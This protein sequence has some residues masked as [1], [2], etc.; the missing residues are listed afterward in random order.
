LSG[1]EIRLGC[2]FCAPQEPQELSAA[3]SIAARGLV[4]EKRGQDL[5]HDI[6]LGMGADDLTIRTGGANK[7]TLQIPNVLLV[8]R[9][10]K[11][12]EKL[13]AVKPDQ[14]RSGKANIT[15]PTGAPLQSIV[16]SETS[17]PR[18]AEILVLSGPLGYIATNR[19]VPFSASNG[20]RSCRSGSSSLS[21]S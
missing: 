11:A 15:A 6:I 8:G 13:I 3:G 2:R 20:R 16:G 7:E 9:R 5:F 18:P 19:I 10:M 4:F 1:S 14:V 17:R 12:I 21:Y